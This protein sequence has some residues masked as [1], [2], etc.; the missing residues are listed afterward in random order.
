MQGGSN[1]FGRSLFFETYR[2]VRGLV[3]EKKKKILRLGYDIASR[4]I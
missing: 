2:I 3:S 1:G 4:A